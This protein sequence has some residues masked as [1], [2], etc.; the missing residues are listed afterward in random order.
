MSRFL[1]P[2]LAV[3]LLLPLVATGSQPVVIYMFSS[4][5][6]PHC[7]AQEPFLEDLART[8]PGVEL[9]RFEV[10]RTRTHHA[11]FRAMA[12]SHGVG[13]ESVPA[14]FVGGRAWI[15]DSAMIRD[16]I[17][18]RVKHCQENP[19][20]DSRALSVVDELPDAWPQA[21]VLSLPLLGDINLSVQPLALATALIALIDGF[22]PC[23]LWVLTIL[24]ALVVHS[25]SRRRVLIVGTTFL[26]VTAGIYGV[27]ITGVFGVLSYLAYLRW[28]Y[29]LVA[30]FAILFA[31]VNIKDYFWFKRGLSFTI[32]D[33]HKPGIFRGIRGLISEGRSL[34]A[35]VGATALMAAGIA[36]IELPCTA[37]FPVIWGSLIASHDV[38]WT[39]FALLLSL[40]LL[41]YLGIELVIFLVAVISLRMKR[42]EEGHGRILKLIGGLIMLMLAFL[43][44][45]A[46]D[47]MQD[48][49][50]TLMAF[51][52]A[53]A[54]AGLVVLLH[55]RI[56]PMMG[57]RIGDDWSD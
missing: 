23:S 39:Y 15:G 57:L 48:V 3:L 7:K 42:F 26:L 25:G 52:G 20:Q 49:T 55:R 32:N 41:I 9:Q 31:I 24:M 54:L 19:C 30:A 53:L 16:A 36:L 28:V 35:L 51:L 37:G 29:W 5:R 44:L 14:V 46:P 45:L 34:P 33:R 8:Q 18:A 2:L 1:L 21:N 4:D 27:F 43:L 38:S 47:A 13:A 22:N 40:Y 56:L 12:E 6:C 11:L 17:R 50:A 10:S